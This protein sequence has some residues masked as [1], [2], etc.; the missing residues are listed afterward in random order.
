LSVLLYWH[1][2]AGV[3]SRTCTVRC[4]LF[5]V[6]DGRCEAVSRWTGQ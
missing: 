3:F 1:I 2:Q 6:Q 4:L 5:G